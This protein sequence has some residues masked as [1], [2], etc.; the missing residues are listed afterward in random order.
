[1]LDKRYQVFVS[2]SG[3]EMR[4][5]RTVIMQT[6]MSM[7]FFSWGLEQRSPL[8]TALARRQIEECD[9]VLLLLGSQ[10]GACS[11]SGI[12]YL[13]LDYIYAVTKQK[14]IIVFMHA[15]PLRHALA[16]Q[17]DTLSCATTTATLAVDDKH[18][19]PLQQATQHQP[20]LDDKFLAFRQQLQR[21]QDQVF[22]Y[23]NCKDLESSLRSRMLQL[24][25]RYPVVGWVRPQN[26]QILQD[27]IDD[28]KIKLAQLRLLLNQQQ[29]DPFLQLPEV[30]LDELFRFEYQIHAYQEGNFKEIVLSRQSNW[31][32][33][34]KVLAQHFSQPLPEAFF[35][36]IIND[37]LNRVALSDVQQYMP[38]AQ[39][40]ARAQ[41]NVRAL[42]TIKLQMR[43]NEWI[44]PVGRDD[45]Q[46]MLW[47]LTKLG[48]EL[49]ATIG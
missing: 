47:K 11:S 21:D 2:S 5:E 15:E 30:Q 22:C 49:A 33:I 48:E 38:H 27:E 6:L 42:H 18:V 3:E 1:M 26:L 36:K 32:L 9:Y 4:P 45:R 16:L 12:G 10:Y 35:P 46:Q 31:R 8:G 28:L 19:A 7:G 40:V 39:F 13:H 25:E 43:K 37:E 14:P 41:I 24:L 20:R 17:P 34:L 23:Q 29:I 44:V